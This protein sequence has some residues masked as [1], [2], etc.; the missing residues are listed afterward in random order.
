MARG[1]PPKSQVREN[2]IEVL[3]VLKRAYGYELYKAYIIVFPAV[4]MRTIYYHLRKGARYGMF[5]VQK[6]QIEPGDY[7]WGPDAEKVYYIIG[8]KGMPKK[9]PRVRASL[10]EFF[11]LRGWKDSQ[12]LPEHFRSQR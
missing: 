11:Q 8:P 10:K 12:A 3:H 5:K 4:S 2:L 6:V 1:R 7:S 9:D